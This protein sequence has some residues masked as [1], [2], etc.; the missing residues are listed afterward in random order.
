MATITLEFK[1]TNALKAMKQFIKF[2]PASIVQNKNDK[3][4][5]TE[6]KLPITKAT[7]PNIKAL[8]GIWKEK[9]NTLENLRTQ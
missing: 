8:A 4:N 7:K 3:N 5:H 9:S 1:D 2:F 6:D